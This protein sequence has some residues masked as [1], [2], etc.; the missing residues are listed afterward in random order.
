MG[1]FNCEVSG[2]SF[3]VKIKNSDEAGVFAVP[4][5]SKIVEGNVFF[6]NAEIV[7]HFEHG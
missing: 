5:T 1:W 4:L 3:R 2:V 7:E 6:G